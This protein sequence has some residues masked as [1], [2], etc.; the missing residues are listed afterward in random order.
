M[1]NLA[2]KRRCQTSGQVHGLHASRW[3]AI[4]SGGY[5]KRM[6]ILWNRSA[7]PGEDTVQRWWGD[8]LRPGELPNRMVTIFATVLLRF[9]SSFIA[10][11]D[12]ST[13]TFW[14][15]IILEAEY[16]TQP[17]FICWDGKPHRI[18]VAYHHWIWR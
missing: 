9:I 13:T 6:V 17:E 3:P 2:Q 11:F 8:E 14:L 10:V 7:K 18:G 1:I 4:P 16:K 5:R 12:C 15:M